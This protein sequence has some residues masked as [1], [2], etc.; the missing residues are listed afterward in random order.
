M[1]VEIMSDIR[2]LAPLYWR[3]GWGEV[4]AGTARVSILF[5]DNIH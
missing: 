1:I 5:P 4:N 3:G 2:V